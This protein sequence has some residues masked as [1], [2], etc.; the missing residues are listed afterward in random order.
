MTKA[1]QKSSTKICIDDDNDDDN[2][3]IDQT[4]SDN[5]MDDIL[6]LDGDQHIENLIHNNNDDNDNDD[7]KNNS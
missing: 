1:I 5:H 3:H 2:A 7:N 6:N 4:I